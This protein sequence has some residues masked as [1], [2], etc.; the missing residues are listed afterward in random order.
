MRLCQLVP[1][2]RSY[3]SDDMLLQASAKHERVWDAS[4]S[5]EERAA[6]AVVNDLA[7]VFALLA[8]IVVGDVHGDIMAIET[9]GRYMQ[10]HRV[11]WIG[12]WIGGG[13]GGERL[14][15]ANGRGRRERAGGDPVTNECELI[16][17]FSQIGRL[18]SVF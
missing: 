2:R 11:G 10:G 9:D 5:P 12:G 4:N 14:L 1:I 16:Y 7:D 18:P 6:G 17:N 15:I 3:I 13:G 8:D